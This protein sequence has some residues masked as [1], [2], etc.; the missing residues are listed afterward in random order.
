MPHAIRF[1]KQTTVVT[2][3]Q[4]EGYRVHTKTNG[5]RGWVS[6]HLWT[7]LHRLKALEPYYAAVETV[8]IEPKHHG[9]IV[10]LVHEGILDVLE[11][12]R[13]LQDF[14]LVIGAKEF[15]DIVGDIGSPNRALTFPLDTEFRRANPYPHRFRDIPVHVLPY[16][17][18]AALIEKKI[19][20]EYR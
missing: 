4:P 12:G 5:W 19:I 1:A 18:G 16:V 2:P 6:K 3:F 20:E 8:T 9:K 17:S 13:R 10:E 11:S 15:R 7:L 14:A